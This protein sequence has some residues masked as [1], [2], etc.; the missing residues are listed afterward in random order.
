MGPYQIEQAHIDLRGTLVQRG[1]DADGKICSLQVVC[2]LH[3]GCGSCWPMRDDHNERDAVMVA[4]DR[5]HE[6]GKKACLIERKL[7]GVVAL[8]GAESREGS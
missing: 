8:Y 5:H 4:L 3:H 6:Q 7:D 1:I 2:R